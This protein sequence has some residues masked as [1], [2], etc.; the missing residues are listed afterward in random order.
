MCRTVWMEENVLESRVD[1]VL[2]IGGLRKEKERKY[3]FL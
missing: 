2:V 3:D 1:D